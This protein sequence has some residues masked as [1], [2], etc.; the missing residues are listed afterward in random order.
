MKQKGK[1]GENGLGEGGRVSVYVRTSEKERDPNGN[2]NKRKQY[3]M[4]TM[5][6]TQQCHNQILTSLASKDRVTFGPPLLI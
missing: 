6:V 1:E 2:T 5:S 3:W 4:T